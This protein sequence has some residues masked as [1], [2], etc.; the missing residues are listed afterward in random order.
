M[1]FRATGEENV[2]SLQAVSFYL[3]KYFSWSVLVPPSGNL[4]VILW[5]SDPLE[6]PLGDCP[7]LVRGQAHSH[8]DTPRVVCC[9]GLP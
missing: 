7:R 1:K 5:P 4:M 3:T 6:S 8:I 9:T 2:S